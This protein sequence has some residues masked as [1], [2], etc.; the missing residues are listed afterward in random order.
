LSQDSISPEDPAPFEA[1]VREHQVMV[2][3]TLTRLLGSAQGVDDLAQE[4]FLRLFRSLPG[5][6]GEAQVGT[7]LYRITVNVAN[8]ALRRRGAAKVREHSLSDE[9]QGWENRLPH[10]GPDAEQALAAR[11]FES[12]V[13]AALGELKPAERAALVLYHQEE[14]SYEAIAEALGKPINTVRTHLSRGRSRLRAILEAQGWGKGR[15]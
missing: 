4:V 14:L 11:E 10:S 15:R 7:Y 5:F 3:R 12:A 13:E 1:L 9:D 8:D 6:R 2:F